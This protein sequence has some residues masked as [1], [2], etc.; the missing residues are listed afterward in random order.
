[1][2]TALAIVL[3]FVFITEAVADAR[4]SRWCGWYARHRLVSVDPGRVYNL[5]CKWLDW[6]RATFAQTGAMVVWCSKHHRHVGKITG[7]C[8]HD[9][10]GLTTCIVTSGNDGRAVRTRARV[11]SGAAF[12]M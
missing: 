5:A 7:E 12:R 3:M 9:S 10:R 1:M 6:G 2:R 4:P 8:H 11:V